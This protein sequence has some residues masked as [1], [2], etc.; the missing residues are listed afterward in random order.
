MKKQK[1]HYKNNHYPFYDKI[2]PKRYTFL[3]F[4]FTNGVETAL[5]SKNVFRTGLKKRCYILSRNLAYD[6]SNQHTYIYDSY[7]A[8]L[9]ATILGKI[10][11]ANI[12]NTYSVSNDLEFDLTDK[13]KKNTL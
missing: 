8:E 9:D 12:T 13:D 6:K 5:I 1:Y 4:Y 3:L 2:Y 10:K 11:V 7:N